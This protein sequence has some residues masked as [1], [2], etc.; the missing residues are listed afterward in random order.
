[1][2]HYLHL[3]AVTWFK[4]ACSSRIILQPDH[5]KKTNKIQG[6]MYWTSKICRADK[7]VNLK[8]QDNEEDNTHLSTLYLIEQELGVYYQL[9]CGAVLLCL[10]LLWFCTDGNGVVYL[11]FNSFHSL[12]YAHGICCTW[13]FYRPS[14]E[15]I[16]C[17]L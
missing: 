11:P 16:F 15:C 8:T 13:L 5:L 14:C 3:V 1:M 12:E 9:R 17:R 7:N 6:D 2:F 4:P 10:L